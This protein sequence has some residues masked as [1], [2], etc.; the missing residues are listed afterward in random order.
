MGAEPGVDL[1]VRL[2]DGHAF[3]S[4]PEQAQ[5]MRLHVVF[6]EL[7]ALK[8][9]KSVEARLRK[10]AEGG[11]RIALEGGS[12]TGK[13]SVAR[14]VFGSSVA[15]VAPIFLRIA[16]ESDP[17]VIT[18]PARFAQFLRT[19]M[20]ADAV[21]ATQLTPE[22]RKRA[23]AG[24]PVQTRFA[25]A[26]R[27]RFAFLRPW[28]E[29]LDMAKDVASAGSLPDALAEDQFEAAEQILRHVVRRG[30]RPYLIFD[31]TDQL[32]STKVQTPI[33]DR[34]RLFF[35][36]VLH[37]VH[38]RLGCG[39]VVA[40]HPRYK[41]LDGYR[42]AVT[43]FIEDRIS[44]PVLAESRHLA[45]ILDARVAGVDAGASVHD[46]FDEGA[47]GELYVQYRYPAKVSIRRAIGLSRA[48]LGHAVAESS[49][50]IRRQ[51]VERAAAEFFIE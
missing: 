20:S 1:L 45:S 51:H 13:S 26:S 37:M 39:I 31:D 8:G 5:I 49:P 42:R 40:V 50:R 35:G 29:D 27:R 47:L 23:L 22:D 25:T 2:D 21:L 9:A 19:V 33:E 32:F 43:D 24:E 10:A 7:L 4:N 36:P 34:V 46:V 41:K 15:R 6:D 30:L 28:L 12:G 48:A 18:Q 38:E 11:R 44:M 14:Y 3:D 16:F 17:E